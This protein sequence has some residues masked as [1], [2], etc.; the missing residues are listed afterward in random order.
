MLCFVA[1]ENDMLLKNSANVIIVPFISS[2]L[3]TFSL[4][5]LPW[6]SDFV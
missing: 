4:V 1:S 3:E 5:T 2:E 6:P